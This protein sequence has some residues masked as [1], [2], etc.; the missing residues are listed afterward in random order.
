MK[1]FYVTTEGYEGG[2]FTHAR[3]AGQ[4]RSMVWRKARQHIEAQYIMFR[5][6][7]F[8]FFDNKP[9]TPQDVDAL[10]GWAKCLADEC[11]CKKGQMR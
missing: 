10:G 1:A 4:A 11:E 5:A 9:I 3:T 2:Q 6:V 7:R 8:P